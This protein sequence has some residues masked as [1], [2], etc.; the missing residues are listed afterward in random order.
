MVLSN[1]QWFVAPSVVELSAVSNAVSTSNATEYTFSSQALGTASAS[2]RI[3]VGSSGHLG[4]GTTSISS[5]TINGV[6]AAQDVAITPSD[7]GSHLEIW[8]AAVPSGTSGDIVVTWGATLSACG[9]GAWAIYNAAS[10]ASD[11]A[12]NKSNPLSATIDCP[13][14]GAII[15]Y[16]GIND[17]S[18]KSFAWTNLTENFDGEVDPYWFHSGASDAFSTQQS[19]RSVTVVVNATNVK[20]R[21]LALAS[22][23]T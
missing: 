13:A 8:S 7:G 21:G 10:S 18:D 14:G 9:I 23:G 12:T 3:V 15:G 16:A 17:D 19:S 5:M 11:T 4:S 6:S 2:R 1:A 22:W 20:G